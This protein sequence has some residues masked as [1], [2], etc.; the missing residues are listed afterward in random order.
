MWQMEG[1]P[2]T[3]PIKHLLSSSE[4]P[5][6]GTHFITVRLKELLGLGCLQ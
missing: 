2:C 5:R 4:V 6:T 1:A 3:S